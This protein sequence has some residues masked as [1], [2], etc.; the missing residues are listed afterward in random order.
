MLEEA[1]WLHPNGN[2]CLSER[3]MKGKTDELEAA[4]RGR[5][6]GERCRRVEVCRRGDEEKSSTV[7]KWT[8]LVGELE[9]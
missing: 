9:E 7:A 5:R 1:E 6:N 4:R 8:G 2:I 3:W